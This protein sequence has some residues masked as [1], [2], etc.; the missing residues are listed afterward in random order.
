M[1][2]TLTIISTFGVLGFGFLLGFWARGGV[3]G[4][5]EEQQ[6]IEQTEL[7]ERRQK[8][9]ERDRTTF[10]DGIRFERNRNRLAEKAFPTKTPKEAA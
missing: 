8:R 10:A 6:E 1:S 9:L 2:I 5:I 7:L 3:N 4:F